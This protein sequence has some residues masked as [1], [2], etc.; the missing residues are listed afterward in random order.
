MTH[1]GAVLTWNWVQSQTDLTLRGGIESG[2]YPTDF[3]KLVEGRDLWKK[4]IL[5]KVKWDE[6]TFGLASEKFSFE[7]TQE[8]AFNPAK[9]A[10]VL[11]L[12]AV[13]KQER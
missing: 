8:V 12:G 13:L 10:E 6:F 3:L 11:A 4:D 1:C 7:R 9:M 2:V 5:D